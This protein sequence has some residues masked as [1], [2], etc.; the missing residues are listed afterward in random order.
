MWQPRS[1]DRNVRDEEEF[2]V[3][4]RYLH[5]NPVKRGLGKTSAD[6][7]WSSFRHYALQEKGPVEIE[8]Q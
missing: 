6:W 3:K 2:T 8:S 7:K 1:F 5:G 4:L